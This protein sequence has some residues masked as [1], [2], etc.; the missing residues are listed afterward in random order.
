M[1]EVSLPSAS[2]R[3]KGSAGP[4]SHRLDWERGCFG[5][6]ACQNSTSALASAWSAQDWPS[7]ALP[8]SIRAGGLEWEGPGMGASATGGSS[9]GVSWVGAPVGLAAGSL[10]P[11]TRPSARV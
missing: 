9:V 5:G 8:V 2:W 7:P 6:L 4:T 11:A 1:M 10:E 3:G